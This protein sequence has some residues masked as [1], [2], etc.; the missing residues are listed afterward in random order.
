MSLF[1]TLRREPGYAFAFIL[2]L[3]LGIGANTAIFSLVSGILLQPL[4]YPHADRLVAVKQ[5]ATLQGQDDVNFSFIEIEDYRQQSTSLEEVVEFGDWTFNVLDRGDPHRATAGLVTA[6]F[7][8]VL[9]M[10]PYSGRLFLEADEDRNAAP[11][12]VV[13]YEYWQESLGAEPDIVGQM[14]DLTSVSAEIVG[15][16]APGAHYAAEDRKQDFYANYAS[17]D[18]YKSATMQ[19]DR[20]HRMTTVFA[21]LR[22]GTTVEQAQADLSRIATSLHR[23]HP[24]DYPEDLGLQTVVVPWKEQLTQQARPVLY[25][26][27]AGSLLVLLIACANV[28]N[29]TLVRA[30]RRSRET[31]VRAALGGTP[32]TLRTSFFLDNLW[33]ALAGAVLGVGIAFA[34]LRVLR[35]YA[36]TL[37]TRSAEVAL[38]VRVLAATLLVAT[39]SAAAFA[40]LPG[41]AP[42]KKLAENLSAGGPRSAGSAGRSRLQRLL[43]VSQLAVSFLLL[44]GSIQ[45]GRTLYNLYAIDPGFELEQVL[46]VEA[47]KFS[48]VPREELRRFTREAVEDVGALPGVEGAAMTGST[49]LGTSRAR[50]LT[51]QVEGRGEGDEARAQPTLFETV[52]PGYFETLGVRMVRGREFTDQDRD[53]SLRVAILNQVAAEHYF[54]ND[55]PVGRRITYDFGGFFGGASDWLTIIGVAANVRATGLDRDPEH[56]LFLPE[57][58]SFAPSTLLVRTENDPYQVAGSV[59]ERLRSLDPERPLEHMRTLEETRNESIA[60]QRLNALLFGSFAALALL[61]ATVGVGAML[62]WSVNARR[63]ELAIRAAVGAEPGSLLRRVLGEGTVLVLVGLVL[64][65]AV[66]VSAG[67]LLQSLL[68]DVAATDAQTLIAAGVILLAVGTLA[69][70]IPARSAMRSDPNSLLR[71]E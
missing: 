14:L 68:F 56:T 31:S 20:N 12:A 41:I 4:P 62:M 3:G 61:I 8:E 36:A 44:F 58:Q 35:A 53:D 27:F 25:A 29:L 52:T 71:A 43:V 67:R 39:A 19:D 47:P 63:R 40:L 69:A 26:T 60:P 45:L 64:G 13:T 54:G 33:L 1:R 24:E 51:V 7:F 37:T 46:S 42:M 57:G 21:R 55:D 5:P 50:P 28:A 16:L 10:K 18:H 15:V 17:N 66:A 49:P 2:T 34:L 32:G 70:M 6:N 23:E 59:L 48:R 30:L 22:E 9:G 38:D 11:V 65:G